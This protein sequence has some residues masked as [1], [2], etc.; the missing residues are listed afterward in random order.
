MRRRAARVTRLRHTALKYGTCVVKICF[1]VRPRV[2]LTIYLCLPWHGTCLSVSLYLAMTSPM[3][4][5]TRECALF[6]LHAAQ[7]IS[8]FKCDFLRPG[9]P[10]KAVLKWCCV[11]CVTLYS[12]K[13]FHSRHLVYTK[14][15]RDVC[16]TAPPTECLTT[17]LDRTYYF[18]Q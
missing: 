10:Y 8:S 17:L 14:H 7:M 3:C 15:G 16:C 12:S 1:D 11:H 9:A 6:I 13:R 2:S 18:I 4:D 5:E